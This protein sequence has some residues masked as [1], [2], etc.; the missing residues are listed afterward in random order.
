MR[1]YNAVLCITIAI[2]AVAVAPLRAAQPQG[3]PAITAKAAIVVDA[4]TGR[5]LWSHRAD[6]RMYPASLTKMMTGLLTVEAGDLDQTVLISRAAARVPETGLYLEAGERLKVRELLQGAL[7]WSA[8]DACVALA[9][10]VAGSLDGFVELMNT[11]ARELGAVGTRFCNPHGLHD[12]AHRSTARDLAKIAVEAMRHP[13][14]RH[15]VASKQF[16]TSRP[17]YV[18]PQTPEEKA[19]L[20]PGATKLR[21]YAMRTLRNRNRLLRWE[22]CDGVKTG[23]TRQAGRCLVASASSDG[24]QAIAVVLDAKDSWQ[25][26]RDLLEWAFAGYEMRRLVREGRGSWQ[27]WVRRGLQP[28]VGALAAQD[29]DMLVSTNATVTLKP[30]PLVR[31]APV[32]RGDDVGM[33]DVIVDGSKCTEVPLVASQDVG[34]SVWGHLARLSVPGELQEL[35]LCLAAGVLMLGACTKTARSCRSCLAARRRATH[36]R[37]ARHD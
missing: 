30:R 9:R 29:V 21:R 25:E 7:I 31:D 5:E 15:I 28:S 10:A 8:N 14:F 34:L 13:E 23:Y 12:D 3:P 17:E 16:S 19:Q 6:R 20:E 11:R 37:G 35:L 27:V 24:W 32:A 1:L 4:A 18:E 36:P 33:L 26:A 2:G 22:L